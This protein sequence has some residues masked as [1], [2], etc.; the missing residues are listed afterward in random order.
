MSRS[1]NGVKTV[2]VERHRH[3][4]AV[5][6]GEHPMTV[7]LPLREL[8][9]VAPD[10]L[11]VSVEKVG[12]VALNQDAIIVVVIIGIA[13]D[14]VSLF[15]HQYVLI[16]LASDPYRQHEARKSSPY[17]EPINLHIALLRL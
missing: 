5:H 10:L 1:E 13:A 16:E 2:E 6:Q 15:H 7:G 17:N 4:L 9:E 14:V 12:T 3:L 8:R 11:G